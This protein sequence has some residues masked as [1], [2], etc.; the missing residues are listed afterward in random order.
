MHYNAGMSN[1]NHEEGL[2]LAEFMN[3]LECL[4]SIR[5]RHSECKISKSR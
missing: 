3:D 2:A 5:Q 4:G 1:C